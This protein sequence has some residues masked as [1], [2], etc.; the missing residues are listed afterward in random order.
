MR[1]TGDSLV[2]GSAL[3]GSVVDASA[4]VDAVRDLWVRARA[5]GDTG[6][7]L[8]AVR[9]A[10]RA[11]RKL[12]REC[13]SADALHAWILLTLAYQHSELGHVAEAHSLLDQ[14]EAIDPSIAP[15]AATNRGGLLVRIGRPDEA[16]DHFNSAIVGLRGDRSP[17]VQAELATALLN[18]GVLHMSAGRLH[19]ARADT[20]AAQS[21]GQSAGAEVVTFMA[22]HNLGY[23]RF[24]TGDLPGALTSMALARDL[25][26][27]GAIGVPAMDRARVLLSAGLVA[28]AKD[29]IDQAV[30]SFAA[31]RATPDL[32]EALQVSAEVDL[33]MGNSGSARANARRAAR[34]ATRRGNERAAM[35][36]ELLEHRSARLA[37]RARLSVRKARADAVKAEQLAVRLVA[38]DLADDA[39][40]ARL[41]QAEAL[42][43]IGDIAGAG[44]AV[45]AAG[46]VDQSTSAMS[47][48]IR[49]HTRLVSSR[50][51]F[52]T[53]HR[54][55]G[56][57]QIR[58]GLDDLANFQAK[59]GSQDL[60]SAAAIHGRDL[61]RLGLRTAVDTG[62]PAAI[63]Q[64]LE[65]SRAASTRLPVVR[66]PADPV[67]AEELGALRM[68][69]E[70]ARAALLAGKRDPIADRR[71]AEVRRLLADRRPDAGVV[72]LFVGDGKIHAL[73]I[74]A[75]RA[76]H[77][78]LAER[79]AVETH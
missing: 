34:I 48:G 28:E 6:R 52:A 63:L 43:D 73:V 14:A 10:Q 46:G 21:A 50:I 24:L 32:A 31:N 77:L 9:L 15:R 4:S 70:Q 37:R 60:Q 33:L 22:T 78:V 12:R 54:S 66:P 25:M 56:L 26:P 40:E 17:D 36:V 13:P 5:E 8:A 11:L 55:S 76:R 68:A 53:G 3:D 71:V 29:F 7:P 45:A 18:R 58:R 2:M 27:T 65:R 44:E 38:A 30:E 47:L 75:T 64:W 57:T 1:S 16:I 67:L 62:S 69:D 42:L 49:L 39:R 19:A 20:E 51:A 72:A 59:F 74:S 41:L 23:V 79:S 61:A 35:V